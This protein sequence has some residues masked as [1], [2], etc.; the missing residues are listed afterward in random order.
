MGDAAENS[1]D[2]DEDGDDDG[3][4]QTSVHGG[5]NLTQQKMKWNI[6]ISN[7]YFEILKIAN[8]ITRAEKYTFCHLHSSIQEVKSV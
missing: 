1:R 8:K 2:W 4:W 3:D 5:D 6:N 7:N